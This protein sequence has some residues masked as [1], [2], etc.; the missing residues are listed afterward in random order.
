MVWYTKKNEKVG[1]KAVLG[2]KSAG[3]GLGQRFGGSGVP[4]ENEAEALACQKLIR[5]S[6]YMITNLA[7]GWVGG[8]LGILGHY[9]HAAFGPLRCMG[10]LGS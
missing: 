7:G 6:Y 10:V 9:A 3:P 8:P 4:G 2:E 1:S 5:C